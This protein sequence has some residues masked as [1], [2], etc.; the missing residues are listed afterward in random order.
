MVLINNRALLEFAIL[1]GLLLGN[2]FATADPT[3]AQGTSRIYVVS[4]GQAR[5]AITNAFEKYHDM[6]IAASDVE[7]NP[8]ARRWSKKPTTNEWE[9][10][11]SDAPLLTISFHN[12]LVPYYADFD[13]AVTR[14]S[15]N[16]CQITVTTIDGWV[17]NGKKE[18]GIHGGWVGQTEHIPP[19]L[20][21]ETNVL[22]Q[23]EIEM[24]VLQNGATNQPIMVLDS[25]REPTWLSGL[26]DIDKSNPQFKQELI[27]AI[28]HE[29]NTTRREA[30]QKMLSEMT[31]AAPK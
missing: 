8:V 5:A 20:Q 30:Y 14:I 10:A 29:T 3:I 23:I 22:T 2:G 7:Y 6:L 18:M 25:H 31:N 4:L 19:M 21:E 24:R 9:L 13:I 16:Q 11:T 27:D 1:C 12:K 17:P 15:T 26:R 28:Q